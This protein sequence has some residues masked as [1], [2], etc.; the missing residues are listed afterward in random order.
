MA[1]VDGKIVKKGD[2][3]HF[4]SDTEQAGRIV[5]HDGNTLK[6]EALS[7]SGFHG[8]YIGGNELHFINASDCWLEE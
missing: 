3:V 8:D 1:K 4:K 6:L 7:D 5:A 2:I